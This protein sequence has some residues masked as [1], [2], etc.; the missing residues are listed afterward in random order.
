[1]PIYF[2]FLSAKEYDSISV[3]ASVISV[4]DLKRKIFEYKYKS[5]KKTD[6][7]GLCLGTD[8]NLVVINAQTNDCY[9]D[10]MMIPNNT[11]V[12]IRRVPGTRRRKPYDTATVVVIEKQ[13]P[14]SVSCRTGSSSSNTSSKT[15]VTASS[16]SNPENPCVSSVSASTLT[17]L[18]SKRCSEESSFAYDDGFGDDVYV[19]PRTKPVQSS[20]SSVDAE[21]DEDSKIKALVNTP[22]LDWQLE[23]CNAAGSGTRGVNGGGFGRMYGHGFGGLGKKTPP[24]GYI[25]HRCNVPGH[26][27]QHCPTNGDPNYDMKRVRLPTGIPKSMLMPNPDGSY[28]LPS[29]AT[30]VLR[31]NDGSFEKEIV[32]CVPL[33]RSW[34][35]SDLP[36]ELLCSLC[37]QVMKDAVLTSKCCFKSFCDKCIRDHLIISKLKCV[38]GTTNVLADYLIPNMTLRDTI[39]RF[40]ESCSGNS[41]IGEN[42]KSN[43]SQVSNRESANWSQDQMSKTKLPAESF[44]DEQKTTLDNLEDGANKRKLLDAPSQMTKKA[45]TTGVSEGAIGSTRMNDTASQSQGKKEVVEDK[46]QQKLVS[47][48]GG[49]KRRGKKNYD[50]ECEGYLMPVGSY[51][52]NPY[53]AGVQVGMEGYV[54]P[55]YAG[56]AM[57]Y[58][59]SPFGTAFNGVMNGACFSMQQMGR[60]Q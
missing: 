15:V 36:P 16:R 35:V 33:K 2:K 12:L 45:R 29:G 1:M 11:S 23:G 57:N 37:K 28:A 4:D 27:I 55:C 40:S 39:N 14:L 38:C 56:G 9:V 19:I 44:H 51:A 31:P 10:D 20:M 52:Y 48:K 41:S 50:E 49:K 46:V 22:A 6:S 54:A 5:K 7:N 17:S 32:G 24:E 59:L 60:R 42:A 30:A 3:D 21:S 13:Q 43:S 18:S 58:G 26:F 53:W 25:C 47:V 8:L 34:S